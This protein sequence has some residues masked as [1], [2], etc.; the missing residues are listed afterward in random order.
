M[1][2][3][4]IFIWGI[5]ILILGAVVFGVMRFSNPDSL[6]LSLSEPILNTDHTTGDQ[7]SKAV[8]VEYGDYQCPACGAYYPLLKQLIAEY[9]D[10]LLFVFR[11]YPL[12]QHGNAIPAAYAAEAAAKQG[13]FW[14]MHDMLYEHQNDWADSSSAE[15]MFVAYAQSLKLDANQFKK[16]V[17]ASDVSDKVSHD[18]Q[19][20]TASG[21][22][23]TPTFFLNSSQIQPQ[24]YDEFKQLIDAALNS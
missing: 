5:M 1:R 22:S 6:K 16:D 24:S 11:N 2:K 21:I 19:T 4:S 8:L 12:P 3:E 17:D 18:L 15:D 14:E 13:K 23:A 7:S 9:G 20:G 10:R